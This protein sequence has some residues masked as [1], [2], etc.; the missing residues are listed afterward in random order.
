MAWR[1]WVWSPLVNGRDH[2]PR[3][4]GRRTKADLPWFGCGA[5][6]RP[7]SR[8]RR[9]GP[10]GCFYRRES[11]GWRRCGADVGGGGVPPAWTGPSSKAWS[12]TARETS[13]SRV[14]PA[15]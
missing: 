9:P 15:T 2:D 14:R 6:P 10:P 7:R 5:Q 12:S 4:F 8:H 11:A 13:R 1:G 3:S